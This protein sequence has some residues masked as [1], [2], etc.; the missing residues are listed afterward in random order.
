MPTSV[1]LERSL[2]M[3]MNEKLEE[4]Q[5]LAYRYMS[6]SEIATIAQVDLMGFSDEGSP[7][8]QAFLKGRLIRK[9]EYN[10][11]VIDLSNQLSSPALLIESKIA[12]QTY[13]ND[14]RE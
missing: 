3:D 2:D 13:L 6:K 9:A 1:G 11:S 4:I 14:L 10:K 7:L 5:Q 8:Y 12:E